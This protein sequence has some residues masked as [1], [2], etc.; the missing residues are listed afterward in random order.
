[1]VTVVRCS[2][3]RD[4]ILTGGGGGGGCGGHCI[5]RLY[6]TGHC[7]AVQYS[8]VQAQCAPRCN[9]CSALAIKNKL[10]GLHTIIIIYSDALLAELT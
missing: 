2:I 6:S 1:M 7:T 9:V 5:H 3:T 4:P 10:P 8:I